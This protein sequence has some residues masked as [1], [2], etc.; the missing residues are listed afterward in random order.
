MVRPRHQWKANEIDVVVGK[1]SE[2]ATNGEIG[3]RLGMTRSAIGGAILRLEQSGRLPRD[4]PRPESI[5]Q[6]AG[7]DETEAAL[8]F[9]QIVW[10]VF[11][12]RPENW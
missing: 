11:Q 10:E 1:L 7:Q 9:G 5:Y 4:R 6:V 8:V 3:A 12:E 2:G